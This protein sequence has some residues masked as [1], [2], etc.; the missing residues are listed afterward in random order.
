MI[1]DLVAIIAFAVV[2]GLIVLFIY[3]KD[4][5]TDKRLSIYEKAIEDLNKRIFLLEK[6]QKKLM[7]SKETDI[8]HEIKRI[9]NALNFKI[10]EALT[11]VEKSVKELHWILNKFQN[12]M[13]TRIEN[14]EAIVKDITAIA[15]RDE[16]IDKDRI[17]ELFREGMTI[18]EIAK[19]EKIPQGKV[20]FVLKL[21][22]INS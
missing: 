13:D 5:E 2:L 7:L 1:I 4:R 20:E 8:E 15:A 22:N 3:I 16:N 17:I 14:I 11:P 21:A 10:E 12:E 19:Q 9:E 18:D 6:N